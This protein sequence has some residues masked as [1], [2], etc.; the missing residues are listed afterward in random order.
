METY[1]QTTETEYLDFARSAALFFEDNPAAVTYSVNG[2]EKGA[3]MAFRWGLGNDCV[4][5]FRVSGDYDDKVINYTQFI[6][7]DK[8]K[9]ADVFLR[10][11]EAALKEANTVK[12]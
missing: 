1:N 12:M 3:L 6:D 9:L 11:G 10:G 2:P 4:V 7:R 5:V 8:A